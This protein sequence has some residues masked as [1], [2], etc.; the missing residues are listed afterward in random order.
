VVSVSLEAVAKKQDSIVEEHRSLK[1]EQRSIRS[2]CE[3]NGQ[4]IHTVIEGLVAVRQATEEAGAS[5]VVAGELVVG[6]GTAVEE[7]G[8]AVG[9][10]TRQPSVFPCPLVLF[11]F[12]Y[13]LCSDELPPLLFRQSCDDQ[14]RRKLL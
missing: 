1:E 13:I 10:I 2:I 4:S 8:V 3:K 6:L 14:C 9:Q 12:S 7:V 5:A 11:Y